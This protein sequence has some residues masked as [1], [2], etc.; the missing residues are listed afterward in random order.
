MYSKQELY[1]MRSNWIH[2]DGT[3]Q[4]VASEGHDDDLPPFCKTIENAENSCVK[5]SCCW[6][7]DAEISKIY[8]PR[9][10]TT[11]Q[12]QKL[13]EINE[14]L[15]HEENINIERK[16]DRWHNGLSWNEILEYK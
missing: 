14:S 15:K 13:V 8:L 10:L 1:D 7:Y 12:A 3:I 6:G 4:I 11:Y 2:P 9:K 16:I 5:V